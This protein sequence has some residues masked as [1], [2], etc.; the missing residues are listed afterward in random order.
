MKKNPKKEFLGA[1]SQHIR[2]KSQITNIKYLFDFDG[3][4]VY[5]E[6]FDD[7]KIIHPSE[8]KE[9]TGI[10]RRF[11]EQNKDISILT[12]RANAK[13]VSEY[14]LSIDL[15]LPVIA[16]GN[17]ETNAK[18]DYILDNFA[19]GYDQIYFYDDRED[20]LNYAAE[21]L[22]EEEVVFIP[23]LITD[24][25]HKSI[26][27]DRVTASRI[28]FLRKEAQS[29]G[30]FK[31]ESTVNPTI[32]K[33]LLT[34]TDQEEILQEMVKDISDDP[35]LAILVTQDGKSVSCWYC[36]EFKDMFIFA[37]EDLIAHIFYRKLAELGDWLGLMLD[38]KFPKKEP[39]P[40]DN[41]INKLF[42]GDYE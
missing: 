41:M 10:I 26:E 28:D 13:I 32:Q 17:P 3:T 38:Y 36:K 15:N 6:D 16:L 4:I 19:E 25:R 30:E 40:V 18:G 5:S 8:N 12:A 14:L 34:H 27:V 29:K 7:E 24:T 22:Q 11:I 35:N 23:I 33:P 21:V 20:W 39:L 37:D 1:F 42:E 31:T 2:T 9:I